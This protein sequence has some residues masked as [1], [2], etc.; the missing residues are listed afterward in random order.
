MTETYT[1]Q[2]GATTYTYTSE[3]GA[4]SRGAIVSTLDGF[5]MT[6]HIEVPRDNAVALLFRHGT[7]RTPVTVA[8]TAGAV[9]EW[10]GHVMVARWHGSAATLECADVL[11]SSKRLAIPQRFNRNC[12]HVLYSPDCGV[13]KGYQAQAA[14]IDSI[15][16]STRS[17]E[18]SLSAMTIPI[19]NLMDATLTK[20]K[21]GV[22]NQYKITGYESIS[23][24]P[25]KIRL[26]MMSLDEKLETGSAQILPG[27][28]HTIGN[29]SAIFN[30]IENFGGLYIP[31]LNPFDEEYPTP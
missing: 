25:I 26:L 7:P 9:T 17:V 10:S 13:L 29:C 3:D 16:R 28:N 15:N 20:V 18:V 2:H 1:F 11:A 31:G 8:I 12:R 19:S 6:L 22:E 23:T 24:S 21:D 14:T 30:N 5:G 4:I 27:C